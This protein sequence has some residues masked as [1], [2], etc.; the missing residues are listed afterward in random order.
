MGQERLLIPGPVPLEGAVAEEM[1]KPAV[2][3][4]G[5]KWVRDYGEMER[6]LQQLFRMKD[7]R[8]YPLA[9]PGHIGIEAIVYTFLRPEDK[10]LVVD[11]GFF[12]RRLRDVLDAHGIEV[13]SIHSR[14]GTPP[15]MRRVEEVL[16]SRYMRAVFAVHSE[17]S[18]GMVNPLRELGSLAHE[19]GSLFIVD[20]VSSIGGLDLPCEDWR[21]DACLGASQKCLGG[22]PG[23]APVAVR[24][25]I[26]ESVE[27]RDVK[28]WYLNLTTWDHY[29]REWGEWHPQPTTIS[30]N[31]FYAFK[32]AL[33]GTFQEGLDKRVERHRII[34][35]A[36]REAL[37]TLG[38]RT[39]AQEEECSD[40]VSCVYP[41]SGY[42]AP[43]LQ[44]RLREEFG[45]L[46]AG[47]IGELKGE[48]L[49][50][51]HMGPT[52]SAQDLLA[53]VG[54]LGS[55]LEEEGD[56]DAQAAVE[57]ATSMSKGLLG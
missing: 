50:I 28:S 52:A 10:A 5:E 37:R 15:D 9:G 45:L 30:S 24:S 22:P 11:N 26:M 8:V 54:A 12:G 46:V 49:R 57:V 40:T 31:V 1:A 25:S 18:T 53:V 21:V 2:P 35:R 20:A 41:P 56:V 4:Y 34:G 7:A 23:I 43:K 42:E 16:S 3:H 55:I 48:V 17:T 14:W 39:V 36:Y 13:F 38:F 44:A 19:Y 29:R 6:L 33:E 32:V 51:G 47:G 27:A